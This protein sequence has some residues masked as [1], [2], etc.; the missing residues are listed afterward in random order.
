MNKGVSVSK[1][2]DNVVGVR[3]NQ[4]GNLLIEVKGNV[5]DVDRIR[6][7]VFRVAGAEA[8]I[9]TLTEKA[10][11]EFKDLAMWATKKK[12][13]AAMKEVVGP[14]EWASV[15][16]FRMAFGEVRRAAV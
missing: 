12:V 10:M 2:G 14:N 11:V 9:R 1:I 16:E 13:E 3:K 6:E 15:V 8:N 5:S 7:E 4:N